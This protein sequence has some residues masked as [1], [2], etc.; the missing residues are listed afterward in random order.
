MKPWKIALLLA[1]TLTVTGVNWSEELRGWIVDYEITGIA[2]SAATPGS[3]LL[4]EVM[5][6]EAMQARLRQILLEHRGQRA[7]VAPGF[8]VTVP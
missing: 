4:P 2:T 6:A 7:P 8:R 5:D 3:V 1:W